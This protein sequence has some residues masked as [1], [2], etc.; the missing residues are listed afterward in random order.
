M[1]AKAIHRNLSTSFVNL[2]SLV[3]HLQHRKFVGR[4][5]IETESYEAE[6]IF[7]NSRMVYVRDCDFITGR[8]RVGDQALREALKRSQE[9]LG[10]I[11][12]YE[13]DSL[14]AETR[15]FVDRSIYENA[16]KQ[17]ACKN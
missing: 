9:P 5:L 10:L 4:V 6:I 17:R 15:T 7:S 16:K 8:T 12:V 11:S 13:A 1:N 14:I 3:L 2:G